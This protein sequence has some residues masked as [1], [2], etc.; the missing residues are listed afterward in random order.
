MS[1]ITRFERAGW[2]APSRL[3]RN[4]RTSVDGKAI[5][6]LLTAPIIYS[7][8]IPLV[9]LDLWMTLYQWTCFPIYGIAK[10]RRGDYIALDRH[11]LTYLSGIEKI[12]CTY[13]SYANGVIAY[14]REI[15]ARTEQYWCPIKHAGAVRDTHSRYHRFAEYGDAVGYR[16]M[17]GPLRESLRDA[18]DT[19]VAEA[20]ERPTGTDGRAA[21][22]G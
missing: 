19:D 16:Q 15:A 17:L 1:V 22:N 2:R 10:V 4:V 7:V 9:L 6:T 20:C 12:N 3:K 14:I 18:R 13:C 11:R 21:A 5:A 8:F